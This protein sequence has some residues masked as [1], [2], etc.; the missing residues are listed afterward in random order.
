MGQLD[1]SCLCGSL[2][3]TCEAEPMMQVI[4]H[5][6]DCQRAG[7]APFSYNVVAPKASFEVHGDTK[8]VY[9]TVGQETGQERERV[10]CSK[11][12]SQMATFIAEMPDVVAIKAGTLNEP[13]GLTPEM[14]I[15]TSRR[16]DWIPATEGRGEFATGLQ[17]G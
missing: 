15:W 3:Y 12:G 13:V 17:M 9:R 8:A 1:G 16:H 6:R 4:C 2:T 5:C 10:F 11:C 14:E 7:G